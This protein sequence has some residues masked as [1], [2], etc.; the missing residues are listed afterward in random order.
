[1]FPKRK[2]TRLPNYNYSV[3]NGYFV[4]ICTRNKMCMFG[5]PG[6]LNQYGRIA[7]SHLLQI[8]AHFADVKV[9]QYVVMP[10]HVHAVIVIGCDAQ[11]ERSRPFPTLSTIIGLYKSGVSKQIH[12]IAP[13]VPVWQKSFYDRILRDE[14]EYLAACR[15]IEENPLRWRMRETASTLMENGLT[16][17]Q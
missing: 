7:Q 15:Y 1:M 11:S 12:I 9:D 13:D 5:E 4:T 2:A 16:R 17:S 8:P 10:N 3:P 6:A 14:E